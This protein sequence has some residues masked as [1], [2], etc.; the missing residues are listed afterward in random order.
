MS[1]DILFKTTF[2][3]GEEAVAT[4]D[5]QDVVHTFRMG[6]TLRYQEWIESDDITKTTQSPFKVKSLKFKTNGQVESI[7]LE[8]D[9]VW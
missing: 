6:Q 3:N 8:E 2:R 9:I 1:Y 4:I 7:E 5:V